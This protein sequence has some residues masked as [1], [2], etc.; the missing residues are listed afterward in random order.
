MYINSELIQN[1]F[2]IYIIYSE[3]NRNYILS[4]INS[5]YIRNVFGIHSECRIDS[6]YIRNVFGM[7]SECNSKKICI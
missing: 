2:R 6:E 4:K 7:Y 3:Y 1:V 5:E